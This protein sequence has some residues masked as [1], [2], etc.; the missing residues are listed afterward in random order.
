LVIHGFGPPDYV[1]QVL[2]TASSASNVIVSLDFVPYDELD[3][4]IGG[5]DIGVAMYEE[6]GLNWQLM[7]SA[8][9]KVAQYLK[10]GVPVIHNNRFSLKDV[11]DRF[12]CGL[13]AGEPLELGGAVRQIA[14]DYDRYVANAVKCFNE[15]YDYNLY[16]GDLLFRLKHNVNDIRA[17][18][19]P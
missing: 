5:A 2:R 9:S 16:I 17:R 4:L 19:V 8:S 7:G 10:L 3:M 13:I 11:I 6:M 1:H 14:A 15:V 12:G 18:A